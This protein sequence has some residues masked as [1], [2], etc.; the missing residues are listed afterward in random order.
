MTQSN[1]RE[2]GQKQE[3]NVP[4]RD[5]LVLP[6]LTLLTI[7]LMVTSTE[8]IAR[9]IFT[10]SK[11]GGRSCAAID[12]PADGILPTPNSVCLEKNAETQLVEYRFNS[13]GHR[14]GMECGP[15]LPGTYR[16]V[17]TGSSF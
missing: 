15:K 8:L 4:W 13:C 6:V 11:T 9:R 2:S 10:E 17:M 14:A 16:I 7:G 3:A 12:D 5:W 1:V